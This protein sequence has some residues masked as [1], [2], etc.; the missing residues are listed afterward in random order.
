MG[1]NVQIITVNHPLDK[2]QRRENKN[3]VSDIHIGNDV[4]IGAGVIILPG[5]SIADEV[6]IGAGSVVTKNL[7][8]KGVYVGNPARKVD[9]K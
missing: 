4:W 2:I 8:T 3:L 5:V 9:A 1:P 7:D 6:V